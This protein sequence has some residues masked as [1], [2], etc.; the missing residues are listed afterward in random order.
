MY[1]H[2]SVY[3]LAAKE[4]NEKKDHGKMSP[5]SCYHLE[6]SPSLSIIGFLPVG[7]LYFPIS[8]FY[9]GPI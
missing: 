5:L 9:L 1:I 4:I 3:I 8:R 2:A 7:L 6:F